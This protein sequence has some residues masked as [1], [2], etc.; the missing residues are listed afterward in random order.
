LTLGEQLRTLLLADSTVSGLVG[1]RVYPG[2]M[3]E[4]LPN[5][6]P[7]LPAIV[8]TVVDDVPQNAL[9]EAASARLYNAR[10]QMDCYARATSSGGAYATAHQVAAAVQ[11]VIGNLTDP[12]LNSTAA[13]R[14]DLYDNTTTYHRVSMDFTVWHS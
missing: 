13:T 4:A 5:A 14:R 12:A 7:T 8:Y 3:P 6:Q 2:V 9:A 10:V 1:T 11:N